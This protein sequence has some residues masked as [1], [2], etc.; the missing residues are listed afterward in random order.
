MCKSTLF[1]RFLN[2]FYP[3]YMLISITF[4]F[5]HMLY[6]ILIFCS[7][8]SF[9]WIL[10]HSIQIGIPGISKTISSC[11]K[12]RHVSSHE[13]CKGQPSRRERIKKADKKKK[14][15][16]AFLTVRS[17]TGRPI[18]TTISYMQRAK[19]R[20]LKGPWLLVHW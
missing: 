5:C 1:Y 11:N 14:S 2:F 8:V 15:K 13:G 10:V 3:W 16:T 12:T 18:Y 6:L 17:L 19:V 20:S 9:H 7:S 4:L